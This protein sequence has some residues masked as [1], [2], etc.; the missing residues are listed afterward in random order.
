MIQKALLPALALTLAAPAFAQDA[1]PPA[2]TA[3][4]QRAIEFAQSL[5]DAFSSVA[6]RL[7]DSVVSIRVEVPGRP[8]AFSNL[9]GYGSDEGPIVRGGGSGVVFRSDGH[10][11]TNNHVVGQA[12]RIEVRLHDGRTFPAT[13]VGTDPA[14]DLAVIKI[15]ADGLPA[16]PF[17]R[18][19]RIRVGE[20]AVAIGSP[21]GLDYTVTAGV[22][23]AV[24]RGG[25]G[26]NEI[27]DYIQTDASIN[28]GNSGGPLVNLRGEVIGIN[29]MI[30]GRGTGIG[31]AVVSELADQVA[32]QIIDSGR[33][34]RAYLGVSFQELSPA[35]V[36]QMGLRAG[37]RGALIAG[38]EPDG[39]ADEAGLRAGDVVTHVDGQALGDSQDL[40]RRVI[41]T[42]VGSPMALTAVRDGRRRTFRVRTGVRP[43]DRA[44]Q[45]A[46]EV[47]RQ[48]AAPSGMALQGLSR[49][50]ARRRGVRWGV[51][52]HQVREGSPAARAGI[53]QGDVILEA[54][55]HRVTRPE[56]VQAALRD[57]RAL[58]RVKR[59]RGL[60]YV[61]L[62][63]R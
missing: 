40:F 60:L 59:G 3:R 4:E 39:P 2:P 25:V 7:S 29:T 26:M 17:A 52:V 44:P 33:V 55:R 11:L 51:L 38:V 58:L 16:A 50:D 23:S 45:G 46:N 9:R 13:V 27:E 37:T 28:P 63:V 1:E 42:Q 19:E 34:Q 54:D 8:T 36:Q 41:A 49:Q 61:P 31:F 62:R 35:L 48:G 15:D 14:T 57:G 56:Q 20:W 5:G 10:I 18:R 22:V 53:T 43:V 6:Q 21:F 24:G 32:T 12:R 30:V 47:S